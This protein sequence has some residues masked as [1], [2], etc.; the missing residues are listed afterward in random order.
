MAKKVRIG[1]IISNKMDKTVVVAVETRRSHP[2]YHRVIKHVAKFK[3]HD[4]EN[5]CEMGDQVKIE[6]CRPLSKEKHWRVIEKVGKRAVAEIK[7]SEIDMPEEAKA[8]PSSEPEKANRDSD[9]QPT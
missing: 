2:R 8:R 3:A 9:L 4:A 6:E 7:P 1:W 5:A